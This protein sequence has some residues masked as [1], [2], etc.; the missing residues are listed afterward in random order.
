MHPVVVQR[1]VPFSPDELFDVA[2]DIEDYPN[3]LTNCAATRIM[4]H[5]GGTLLVDNVFRWGPVPLRFRTQ[6]VFN[7]PH[8][9][10]IE[11]VRGESL[12]LKLSWRFEAVGVET[13]VQLSMALDMDV[14][15]FGGGINDILQK[16]ALATEQAFLK[17]VEERQS[18]STEK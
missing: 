14:P 17:R 7:R 4:K 2:A 8:A 1:T 15:V 16:E 6:A 3:F 12:S 11:T 9:I 10:D 18:S 13:S 5:D